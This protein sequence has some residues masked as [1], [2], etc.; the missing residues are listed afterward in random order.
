MNEVTVLLSNILKNAQIEN[1]F[2]VAKK[3]RSE[4][5]HRKGHGNSWNFRWSK[6]HEPC[7]CLIIL[8]VGYLGDVTDYMITVLLLLLWFYMLRQIVCLHL[9]YQDSYATSQTWNNLNFDIFLK[10]WDFMKNR[11]IFK[12]TRTNPRTL[13]P[14][15]T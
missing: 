3:G 1:S 4:L 5:S 12:E 8:I 14:Q 15:S 13:S 11:R 7:H 9:S 10:A 2:G 6:E